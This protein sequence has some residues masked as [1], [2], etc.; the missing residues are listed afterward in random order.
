MRK[1]LIA[2]LGVGVALALLASTAYGAVTIVFKADAKPAKAGKSTGLKVDFTVT[3]PGQPQPPVLNRIVIKLNKGGKYNSSKFPRCKLA[4]LQA[5]GPSGCSRRSRIGTGTGIGRALPVVED[6]VN[7]KLTLFNGSKVGG[8]DTV[9]VY[10]FPDL[11][12]T[13][14]VVCKISKKRSGAFDYT[15]DCG[16]PPIKTLPSAPDAAVVE[17]KTTT[18]RKT[19]R[20]GKRKYALIVAPKTCRRTWKAQAQFY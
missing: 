13:F 15:L 8:R 9:L 12:P 2:M 18:P 1:K 7:G 20:K 3:E 10:V 17:T 11:G 19:I 6:P 5:R 16:I 14:V 4:T